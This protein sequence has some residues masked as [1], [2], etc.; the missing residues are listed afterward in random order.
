MS[1]DRAI[2]RLLGPAAAETTCEECFDQLDV[3]VER[4]LRAGDAEQ[5]MPRLAAHL[6]GCPACAED[7]DG[8]RAL[9]LADQSGGGERG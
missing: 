9:L 6:K 1:T 3:Y 4:D 2:A 5:A 8:L 7:H